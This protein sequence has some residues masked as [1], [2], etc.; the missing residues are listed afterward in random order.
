MK[1]KQAGVVGRR[2]GDGRKEGDE[3]R[4]QRF[5]GKERREG[6]RERSER[7]GIGGNGNQVRQMQAWMSGNSL[8]RAMSRS[9]YLH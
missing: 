3:I 7:R 1:W 5:V 8:P 4:G 6:V 2:R 9:T